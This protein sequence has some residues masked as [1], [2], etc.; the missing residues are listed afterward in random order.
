[1][2]AWIAVGIIWTSTLSWAQSMNLAE[3]P[4]FQ[5]NITVWLKLEPMREA[6]RAI[7]KQVGIL[8]DQLTPAQH[9]RFGMPFTVLRATTASPTPSASSARAQ[10]AV[11]FARVG[12]RFGKTPFA[13]L[14][15]WQRQECRRT[16]ARRCN[17]FRG[18]ARLATTRMPSHLFLLAGTLTHC[19][20][21]C[22][23]AWLAACAACIGEAKLPVRCVAAL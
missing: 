7:S 13:A 1:M 11:A 6:L 8:I 10:R 9:Q 20:S 21:P 3:E 17:A 14:H 12:D 23:R 18:V 16:C 15:T 22:K 4:K 5:Q 19:F 2:R